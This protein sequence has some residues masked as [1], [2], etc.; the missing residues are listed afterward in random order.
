MVV[1]PVLTS[2]SWM[3]SPSP[4]FA[5]VTSGGE[6][7]I[8]TNCSPPDISRSAVDPEQIAD[9]GDVAMAKGFGFMFSVTSAD[10]SQPVVVL[11]TTA[12]TVAVLTI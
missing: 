4:G 5:P 10:V 12:L 8:Q 3:T 6:L 1:A 9:A 2:T 7:T 11:E